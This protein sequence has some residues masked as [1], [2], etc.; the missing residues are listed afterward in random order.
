VLLSAG[1]HTWQRV[2]APGTFGVVCL[3]AAAGIAVVVAW[4]D[5]EARPR[6]LGWAVAL[7]IAVVTLAA[8]DLVFITANDLYVPQVDSTFNRLNLPG[9]AAACVAFVALIGMAYEALRR[10]VSPALPVVAAAGVLLAIGLHQTSIEHDHQASW[11]ESWRAQR[12][13][14]AGYQRA[15]RGAPSDAAVI[16]FDTPVWERGWVPVFSATWDLR[17]AIDYTT[18]VDPPAAVPWLPGTA[19]SAR[20]V[21]LNG[22]PFATYQ[23]GAAPL[24]F[25][26]PARSLAV[27]VRSKRECD[28]LAAKWGPTPFWGRTVSSPSS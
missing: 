22:S 26:S 12:Q 6:V 18:G 4:R 3:L 13:A 17:G 21:D 28:S 11:R 14:L 19:C 1:W 8:T 20:G 16:G 10:F 15:L 23:D 27:R 9:A 7:G 2:F 5:Q 24:Y 25:V